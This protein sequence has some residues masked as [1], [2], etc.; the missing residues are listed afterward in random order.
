MERSHED[1]DSYLELVAA[2]LGFFFFLLLLLDKH[3]IMKSRP[4]VRRY[5]VRQS[6]VTKLYHVVLEKVYC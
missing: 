1:D 3:F 4:C 6:T 5:V 2:I